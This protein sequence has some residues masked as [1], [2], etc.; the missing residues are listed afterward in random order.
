[1]AL[2]LQAIRDKIRAAFPDHMIVEDL[3]NPDCL[4][5]PLEIYRKVA[6]FL[7]SDEE[8]GFDY[9]EFQTC[10][11]HPPEHLNFVAFFRSVE[12]GHRIGLKI[13]MD[14]NH[15]ALPSLADLWAN[16]DWNE[17]EVFDLFGVVFHEHPD[18]RRL[19]M[20]EDWVG[21]PLRKDYLHPNVV[22]R[23]D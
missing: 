21:H 8:L 1:M 5:V 16:A 6:E 9:L 19:M 3:S 2:K 18:L 10:A 14:R 15:P 13:V 7:K 11:D 20:P 23:P 12:K 22:K 4:V 17:R